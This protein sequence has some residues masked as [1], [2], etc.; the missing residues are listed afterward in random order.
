MKLKLNN[1]REVPQVGFGTW[2]MKKEECFNAVVNGKVLK[3]FDKL[4][5]SEK[6][7]NLR[8]I[9]IFKILRFLS[10]IFMF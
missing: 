5:V 3:S 7:S 2:P 4:S 10:V 1:G 8:R 6:F 9:R